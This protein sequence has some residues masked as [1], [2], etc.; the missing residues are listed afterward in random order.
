MA[1]LLGEPMGWTMSEPVAG[2]R[3]LVEQDSN[4]ARFHRTE[5]SEAG[6]ESERI[7]EERSF[8]VADS[9]NRQVAGGGAW[10]LSHDGFLVVVAD[11]RKNTIVV[12]RLGEEI[13]D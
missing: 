13:A 7:E 2:I 11:L 1:G 4:L 10:Q 3:D 9:G 12:C 6:V 5:K 8:A